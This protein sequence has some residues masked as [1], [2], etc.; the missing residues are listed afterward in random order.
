M[1]F[2]NY[3]PI[4]PRQPETLP[5][6]YNELAIFR[7]SFR[8]NLGKSTKEVVIDFDTVNTN[9]PEELA[10]R[11]VLEAELVRSR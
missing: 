9:S 7:Y 10:G 6:A 8:D 4:K 1:T 11:A 3:P 2:R 5:I